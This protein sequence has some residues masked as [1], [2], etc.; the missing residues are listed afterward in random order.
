MGHLGVKD[1]KGMNGVA[2]M[3]QC[4]GREPQYNALHVSRGQELVH[5]A[6]LPPLAHGAPRHTCPVH[7]LLSCPIPPV[8]YLTTTPSSHA[9]QR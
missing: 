4:R 7:G 6:W 5:G 2:C 3:R 1:A 9:G 8:T